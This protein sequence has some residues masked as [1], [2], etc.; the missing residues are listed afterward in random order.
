MEPITLVNLVKEFRLIKIHLKWNSLIQLH[1]FNKLFR[2]KSIKKYK[3]NKKKQIM[4][5]LEKIYNFKALIK[6]N[7]M[8][9]I[10][11]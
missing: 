4:I 8:I 3:L 11:K 10:H 1:N 6:F 2:G 7:K 9:T 5:V